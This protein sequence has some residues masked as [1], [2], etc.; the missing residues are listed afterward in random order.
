MTIEDVFWTIV[1]IF[2]STLLTSIGVTELVYF[3]NTISWLVRVFWISFA[4]TGF[5]MLISSRASGAI[6]ASLVT[7]LSLFTTNLLLIF[8]LSISSTVLCFDNG[9]GKNV[10]VVWVLL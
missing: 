3:S 5:K 6:A 7:E 2:V 1:F 4:S 10:F 8:T 9:S